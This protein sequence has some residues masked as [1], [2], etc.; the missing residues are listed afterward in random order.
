MSGQREADEPAPEAKP[1]PELSAETRR[2]LPLL[3]ASYCGNIQDI[4]TILSTDDVDVNGTGPDGE[5]A[6]LV[7]CVTHQWPT[8]FKLLALDADPNVGNRDGLTPLHVATLTGSLDAVRGLIGHGADV[9]TRLRTTITEKT[10]LQGDTPLHSACRAGHLAVV[11]ILLKNGANPTVRSEDGAIPADVLKAMRFVPSALNDVSLAE[12]I[13]LLLTRKI[14]SLVQESEGNWRA[15]KTLRQQAR[16]LGSFMGATESSGGHWVLSDDGGLKM[17]L[18]SSNWS[19]PGK[20]KGSSPYDARS[21]GSLSPPEFTDMAV[22]SRDAG[23]I[24]QGQA[25]ARFNAAV[26][27]LNQA[28]SLA[29]VAFGKDTPK[30]QWVRRRVAYV[31]GKVDAVEP[32]PVDPPTDDSKAAYVAHLAAES[33][34]PGAPVLYGAIRM[35]ER[36]GVDLSDVIEIIERKYP[37]VMLQAACSVDWEYGTTELHDCCRHGNET[38]VEALLRNGASPSAQAFKNNAVATQGMTPLHYASMKNHLKILKLLLEYGAAPDE[39]TAAVGATPLCYAVFYGSRDCA[40]A[41]LKLGADPSTPFDIEGGYTIPMHHAV[42]NGDTAMAELLFKHGASTEFASRSILDLA[43]NTGNREMVDLLLRNGIDM[44]SDAVCAAIISGY[45]EIA[46]TL[47]E[48]GGKIETEDTASVYCGAVARGKIDEIRWALAHGAKDFVRHEHALRSAVDSGKVECL[49]LLLELGAD[50]NRQFWQPPSSSSF[51]LRSNAA[52]EKPATEVFALSRAVKEGNREMVEMLLDYGA[53]TTPQGWN[54]LIDASASGKSEI[55]ELLLNRGANPNCEIEHIPEYIPWKSPC[56]VIPI[57]AAIANRQKENVRLL[58]EH[59][60]NCQPDG[61]SAVAQAMECGEYDIVKLLL[62]NGADPNITLDEL[63][64]YVD[65]RKPS[66]VCPLLM[67]CRVGKLE[68]ARLLVDHG[69]IWPVLD[70]ELDLERLPVQFHLCDQSGKALARSELQLVYRDGEDASEEFLFRS[71]ANDNGEV[72]FGVPPERVLVKGRKFVALV[73]NGGESHRHILSRFPEKGV[74]RLEV[75]KKAVANAGSAMAGGSHVA[76]EEFTNTIGMKFRRIPAGAFLM[77]TPDS[78]YDTEKQ[79]FVRITRPFDIGV[80]EVTET[81]FRAVMGTEASREENAGTGD[82]ASDRESENLP[83][84]G[85]KWKDA[86]EFCRLLSRREGLEYRLPTEAEWEY[87]CRAGTT[88][89]YYCG[90]DSE[91][92]VRVGNIAGKADGYARRAPIGRFEPNQFGLYDMHGNISEWC[93]DKFDDEFY[94]ES[95]TDDPVNASDYYSSTPH[96]VRGGSWGQRVTFCKSSHRENERDGG[97]MGPNSA[98]SRV[99]FRVVIDGRKS[100]EK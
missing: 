29:E 43:I 90:D 28:I 23:E 53:E 44:R 73:S 82:R 45:F 96:V 35:S 7:A 68:L 91:D 25:D 93:Q 76:L 72:K 26:A 70:Q 21:P 30:W 48:R 78:K 64:D 24:L 3:H 65:Y 99:G 75:G 49:A 79:H 36:H 87:A 14:V 88:T 38:A 10:L 11:Q 60:V 98:L 31:A 20:S 57:Y 62:E 92:I 16:L 58:L 9:D 81:Q 67:A 42:E 39:P 40:A 2:Q 100:A 50:P 12:I 37:H 34:N 74:W 77:G 41:L 84:A 66:F 97:M 52:K 17:E 46:E 51:S 54:V 19:G 86:V 95:P 1:E 15:D 27:G 22:R 56:E 5:T 85:V 83:M 32:V 55:V 4:E 8:V 47:L 6:L 13:E 63:P 69:A 89:L 61:W 94:L 18:E 59:G 80:H 71:W 33:V